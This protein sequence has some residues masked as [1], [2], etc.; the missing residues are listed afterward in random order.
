MPFFNNKRKDFSIQ[1]PKQEIANGAFTVTDS[2]NIDFTY[3][4]NNLTANLIPTGITAGTYG[5]STLIPILTLDNYGRVIGV[6]TTTFSASGITLQTNSVN[7]A[8]Q[9]LLNLIAGTNI[10]L[11]NSGGNVTINASGGSGGILT[12]NNGLNLSTPSNVQLGGGLIQP[13]TINTNGFA[14]LWTGSNGLDSFTVT[15]TGLGGAIKGNTTSGIAVVGAASGSGNGVFGL[16]QNGA[17]VQGYAVT[18]LAGQF[19]IGPSTATTVNTIIELNRF[20]SIA[21]LAGM[22]GAIDFNL[23]SNPG[24][25]GGGQ[26]SRLITKWTDA[27]DATRTA[28]FEIWLRNLGASLTKKLSIAGNGQ[29]TLDEY[30]KTPVN[31][32]GTPIW[33][34]GVDASGNVIEFTPSIGS[35]TVTSIGTA[36][37][38]SGGTITT[39]GTITTLMNTNKLVGR[40]TAGAG[41]MEE[42]TL[43]TGLTLTGTTLNA[44]GGSLLNDTTG[45]LFGGALSATIGGTTFSVTAGIGQIVTQTASISGVVTT[46]NNVTWSAVV[47]AAI[48]NIGTSQFTYV[49]VNSSGVVIQQTTPFT[50]AQYKTHIIIGILCHINLASVNLVTNSQNVAYE[51]PHRLVELITAF[52]P[53]KKSGLNIGPN[54]ANLRVNRTSGEAFKIGTNYILDQFEPDVRI[55]A[56]ETPALLCRVH[57][58]G[59][60]GFIFDVNGGS[61]YNDIDPNNYDNGSGTL[62]SVGGSKWTIQRLFFFPNNPVDIICYYG[63]QVYN[64]FSEARANLEFETFDEAQITAENA[65]FIGFLFV[66]NAATDLSLSTQAAFLQSGLFRG[67]PPGGGGSGGSG[68][69]TSVAATVPAPTS[70]AFSVAVTNPATTPSV[71]I[72]ANGTTSQYV[73]GDGSLETFPNIPPFLPYM[74]EVMVSTTATTNSIEY[75][76]SVNKIYVTNGSN[77]VNIFNATTG[78]LLATVLLTQALRARYIA[79]KNEVWVTSVNVASITRID[80]GVSN[81]V[82]GTITA[83][84]EA[85]GFDICEISPTKVYVSIITTGAQKIQVIDPSPLLPVFVTN[86]IAFVP[87]FASGMAFN[88]NPLSAQNGIVLLGSAGGAVTLV[89]SATNT[90]VVGTT[91][92]NPGSALSNVYEIMYSAVDDKY[93]VSSQANSRVVSLNITGPTTLTLDK[94]KYNAVANISLQIDDANDLLI[95]NQIASIPTPNVMCHFIRKST[96]ESLYN[97]MTPPQGGANTRAGYIKADLVNKRVF[98]AGRSA[99]STAVVTVKY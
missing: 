47:G 35:G 12:A 81:T 17:A 70:P 1:P 22:G 99:S 16:A 54:G 67:I 75:V 21:A 18:G 50:D 95:I 34:L 97:I 56:A 24:S 84:I 61:Y 38:I 63:T 30:G 90:V 66:R 76:P 43:G 79:S 86:I 59:S 98:L 14:T 60:G 87:G 6:S 29:L 11:S 52:G 42:I 49:L 19:S 92:T 94:I 36:G 45:I 20:N 32:P 37:L 51:D 46:V 93:Y 69:V 77:N 73:R 80:P 13:T 25:G 3:A 53:I 2:A 71:N 23:Q 82:I 26:A 41:V 68:T 96:F 83:S 27:L 58:D 8:S 85:N 39:S 89:N 48:T 74:T 44:S 40:G 28:Q 10:T 88:N 78:E 62:Q 7:N 9:V 57:R 64:Q 31:F 65:V 15:N 33:S 91:N 4:N 5:S 55:I 72:T